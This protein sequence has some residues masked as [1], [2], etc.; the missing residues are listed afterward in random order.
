MNN[1]QQEQEPQKKVLSLNRIEQSSNHI[2]A[3]TRKQTQQVSF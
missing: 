1:K 3:G 2:K